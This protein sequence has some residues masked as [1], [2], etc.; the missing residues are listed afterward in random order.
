LPEC[1]PEKKS[2]QLKIRFPNQSIFGAL[3]F[4]ASRPLG[5]ILCL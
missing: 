5:S 2:S 3:V 4:D 1:T